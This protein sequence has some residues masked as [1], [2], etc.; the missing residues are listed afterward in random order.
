MMIDILISKE[1]LD[2]R[3]VPLKAIVFICLAPARTNR[4]SLKIQTQ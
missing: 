3:I 4:I 1:E 2:K